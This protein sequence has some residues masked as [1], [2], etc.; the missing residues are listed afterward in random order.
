MR[1]GIENVDF[2]VQNIWYLWNAAR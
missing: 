2:G 1:E